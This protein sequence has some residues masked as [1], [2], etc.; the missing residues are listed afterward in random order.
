MTKAAQLTYTIALLCGLA[1]G[2]VFGFKQR[3]D[4]LTLLS[5]T[6]RMFPPDALDEFA[7]LQYKN[8]NPPD[9]KKALLTQA[10]LY[11]RL[12]RLHPERMQKFTLRMTYTRLAAL[13][14]KNGNPEEYRTYMDK[15]KHWAGMYHYSPL[16][17]A[18]LKTAS[19]NMDKLVHH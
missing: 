10:S 5:K 15:A 19:E 14:E 8:A 18:E 11:E 1:L 6:N 13:E 9:A 7:Y 4:V 2:S 17:D 3:F 12:E 16:T